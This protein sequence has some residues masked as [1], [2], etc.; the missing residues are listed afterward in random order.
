MKHLFIRVS[1]YLNFDDPLQI[2]IICSTYEITVFALLS[3]EVRL[4]FL[5]K[6][7]ASEVG[8]MKVAF[9]LLLGI[10]DKS[11]FSICSVFKISVVIFST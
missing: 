10:E 3:L 5:I 6:L 9:L 1:C 8:E 11:K 7:G 2:L 4:S